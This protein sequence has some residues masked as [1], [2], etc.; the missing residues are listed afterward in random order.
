MTETPESKALRD[1]VTAIKKGQKPDVTAAEALLSK[2]RLDAE[3]V[4]K[5]LLRA[6]DKHYAEHSQIRVRALNTPN[7]KRIRHAYQ[8]LYDAANT[9]YT[10]ARGAFSDWYTALE[11]KARAGKLTKKQFDTAVKDFFK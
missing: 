7:A 6:N 10:A 1:L 4:T 9:T 11:T 2:H 5:E 3:Y 8:A